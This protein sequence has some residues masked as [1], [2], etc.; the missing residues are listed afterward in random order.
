MDALGASAQMD[1]KIR[2]LSSAGAASE[3][4]LDIRIA[5]ERVMMHQVSRTI[6]PL[7]ACALL[8]LTRF[9]SIASIASIVDV[10]RRNF[11]DGLAW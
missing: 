11:R 1:A 10:P 6:L 8:S 4:K 2:L 9:A 3:E 7:A 5:R